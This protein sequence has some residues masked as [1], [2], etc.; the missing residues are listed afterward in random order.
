MIKQKCLIMLTCR[1][2]AIRS[3]GRAVEGMSLQMTA[4][5]FCEDGEDLTWSDSSFHTRAEYR[6]RQWYT[7]GIRKIRVYT[8]IYGRTYAPYKL[9]ACN[10]TKKS[11]WSYNM[12]AGAAQQQRKCVHV[13]WL[14]VVDL[15][16]YS[17]ADDQ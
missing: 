14:S 11:S 5:N 16:C 8:E 12:A 6:E 17:L 3:K 13:C 1:K 4:E 7:R 2:S 10:I 9:P 15:C